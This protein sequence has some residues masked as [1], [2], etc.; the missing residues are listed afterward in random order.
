MLKCYK[1][2]KSGPL[3]ILF[4]NHSTPTPICKSFGK[5]LMYPCHGFSS[6]SNYDKVRLGNIV[7]TG[8]TV[9]NASCAHWYCY[10]LEKVTKLSKLHTA[11]NSQSMFGHCFLSINIIILTAKIT[12]SKQLSHNL[13]CIKITKIKFCCFHFRLQ[14][15]TT[16]KLK[17]R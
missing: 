16:K 5:N 10:H 2:Q 12:I 14:K 3:E 9:A 13:F 17:I 1:T 11:I 15:V 8:V 7:D 4:K 6:I